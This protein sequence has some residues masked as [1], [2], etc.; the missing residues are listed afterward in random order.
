MGD[1]ANN[2]NRA[3]A[4]LIRAYFKDLDLLVLPELAFSGKLPRLVLF[5]NILIETGRNFQSL[6]H[7]MPCLEPQSAGITALWARVVALKY[8]CDIIVGY[9]EK[10]NE[11]SHEHYN[12]AIMINA[13]GDTIANYRK[14]FLY[15]A[16]ERWAQESNEFYAEAG[17]DRFY[18]GT[19]PMKIPE[20]LLQGLSPI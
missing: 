20:L 13:D 4:I 9:P 11:T 12:S 7:I 15:G 19:V 1:V 18:A 5:G 2:L 17:G 10:V 8:S 16:D 3:D 14:S 6:E